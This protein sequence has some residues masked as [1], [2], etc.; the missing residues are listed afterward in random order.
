MIWVNDQNKIPIKSWC[1]DVRGRMKDRPD[2]INYK[3][4]A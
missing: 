1:D 3:G 4:R 2:N